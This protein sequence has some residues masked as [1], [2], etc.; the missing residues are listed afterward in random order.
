[1]TDGVHLNISKKKAK[2]FF[3]FTKF[4]FFVIL[5]NFFVTKKTKNFVH[6]KGADIV[7]ALKMKPHLKKKDAHSKELKA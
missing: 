1:M 3:C 4:I 7:L 5:K 2:K 6:P